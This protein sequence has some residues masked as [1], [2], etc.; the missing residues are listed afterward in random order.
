MSDGGLAQALAEMALRGDTGAQ[1]DAARSA[2]TR[3]SRCSRSRPPARSSS[4]P[5]SAER[6]LVELC[7]GAGVPVTRLGVVG[8]AL[9]VSP[10]PAAPTG[11]AAVAFSIPLEELRA[12]WTATLP[13]LFA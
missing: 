7:A 6:R 3:S 8:D 10:P 2:S 11:G 5:P 1:V 9:T 13:A 12:T 4:Y